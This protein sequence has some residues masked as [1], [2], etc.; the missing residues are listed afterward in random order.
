MVHISRETEVGW[1]NHLLTRQ[2]IG[3]T[4]SSGIT[5]LDVCSRCKVLQLSRSPVGVRFLGKTGEDRSKEAK[6][7]GWKDPRSSPRVAVK[8]KLCFVMSRTSSNWFNLSASFSFLPIDCL[9][10]T[11]CHFVPVSSIMVGIIANNLLYLIT[12]LLCCVSYFR[13][14]HHTVAD[15][16]NFCLTSW[17]QEELRRSWSNQTWI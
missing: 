2:D 8:G 6:Q 17:T 9:I 1:L 10:N 14:S 7:R 3:P 5:S 16:P 4:Q 15:H 13:L 12:V 11:C